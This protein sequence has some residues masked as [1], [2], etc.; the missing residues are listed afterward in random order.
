MKHLACFNE[1]GKYTHTDQSDQ[2][3]ET[4]SRAMYIMECEWK[5]TTKKCEWSV[6][7]RKLLRN[8]EM[9]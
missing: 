3:D 4:M 5:I 1:N 2:M 9:W 6:N 7:N 8:N